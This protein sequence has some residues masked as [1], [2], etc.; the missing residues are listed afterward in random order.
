V[1]EPPRG[2]H[3][4]RVELLWVNGGAS[5]K[6]DQD[7]RRPNPEPPFTPPAFTPLPSVRPP[8]DHTRAA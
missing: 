7:R 4:V 1:S 6:G 5:A 3:G 8:T 2:R